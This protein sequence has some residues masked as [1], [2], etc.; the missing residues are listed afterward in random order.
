[1]WIVGHLSRRDGYVGLIGF[2][3]T[4]RDQRQANV[5]HFPKQAMQRG[6]VYD[7]ARDD[8]GAVAVVGEAHSVEPSGP[9]ASEVH[10]EMVFVSS[11]LV[12]IPVDLSLTIGTCEPMW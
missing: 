9:A 6:M 10:H 11:S 8:G 12:T 2:D 4:D 1:M 5:A 7:R 3:S